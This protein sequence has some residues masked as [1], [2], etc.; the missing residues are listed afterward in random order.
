MVTRSRQ[1]NPNNKRIITV[2]RT[3]CYT[4]NISIRSNS[5][6]GRTVRATVPEVRHERVSVP[7]TPSV[8]PDPPDG[9]TVCVSDVY[10]TTGK[11]PDLSVDDASPGAVFLSTAPLPPK[12]TD[13][14]GVTE[15]PVGAP[16]HSVPSPL[17]PLVSWSVKPNNDI[18]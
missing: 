13:H 14:L 1:L 6:L 11:D 15:S 3:I 9:T 8:A 18:C 17:A 16:F 7:T 5:P 4:L 10:L 12:E 2:N